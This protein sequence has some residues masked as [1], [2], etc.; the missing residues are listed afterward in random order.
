MVWPT[1]RL[2]EDEVALLRKAKRAMYNTVADA[3]INAFTTLEKLGWM[4]QISLNTIP[5]TWVFRL[6]KQGHDGEY[7]LSDKSCEKEA[8]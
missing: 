4:E 3:P 1:L 5:P 7:L 2:N 6:T 8:G